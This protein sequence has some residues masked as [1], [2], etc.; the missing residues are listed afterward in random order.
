[1]FSMD[2]GDFRHKI[3]IL[4]PTIGK[5]QDNIPV[6]NLEELFSTKAKITNVRG[7]ELRA[8]DGNAYKQ[9]KRVYFR[10]VRNKPIKQNDVVLFNGQKFNITYVNNIEEKNRYYEIK[11]ELVE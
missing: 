4:R 3:T 8:G 10:V 7:N 11:M 6:E 1:M 2:S 5:D 9:E